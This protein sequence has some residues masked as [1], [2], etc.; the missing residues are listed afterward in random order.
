MT[1]QV[2]RLTT[3]E[4]DGS[5]ILSDEADP[6][7]SPETAP[8]AG[9]REDELQKLSQRG[10]G[11]VNLEDV[12]GI[13]P[14]PPSGDSGIACGSFGYPGSGLPNGSQWTPQS[15]LEAYATVFAGRYVRPPHSR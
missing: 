6:R 14:G 4:L 12:A 11:Y 3:E 8:T 7:E 5:Q 9:W 1:A 10:W 15:L 13:G 2:A